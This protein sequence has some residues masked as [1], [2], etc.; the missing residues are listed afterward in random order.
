MSR[1][2]VIYRLRDIRGHNKVNEQNVLYG[3]QVLFVSMKQAIP[4]FLLGGEGW[5]VISSSDPQP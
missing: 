3:N 2:L 1:V 4:P 5:R